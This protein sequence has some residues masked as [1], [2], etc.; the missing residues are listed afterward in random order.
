MSKFPNIPD[1]FKHL[2]RKDV[3]KIDDVLMG[4][5]IMWSKMSKDPSTQVGAAIYSNDNRVLSC[6]YNGTPI[7]WP[8]EEFPWGKGYEGE[9]K[10]Y[11]KY[12]FVVH[13]EANAF[14]NY[15]KYNGNKAVLEGTTIY[16]TLFPCSNCAKLIVDH[17]IKKVVYLSDKYNYTPDNIMSKQYLKD[18]GV[19]FEQFES[20][21]AEY[22][23]ISLSEETESKIKWKGKQRT[24]RK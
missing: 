7:G 16:V 9:D 21:D 12:N 6:G 17:G 1:K 22:I 24:R 10:Q 23:K 13:A 5:A 4:Q 8:D 18:K 2:Q 14:I 11:E 20:K 15:F 3:P 19:Q